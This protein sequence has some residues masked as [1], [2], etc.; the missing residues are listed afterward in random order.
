MGVVASGMLAL[1]LACLGFGATVLLASLVLGGRDADH[2]AGGDADHDVGD[3]DLDA[4]ADADLDG[5]LDCRDA[6]P[7]DAVAVA[8]GPCGCASGATPTP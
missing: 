4:H 3:H 8:P 2:E 1:Y 7:V 5:T 6:C